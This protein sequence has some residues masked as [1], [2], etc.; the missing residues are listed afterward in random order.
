M[1]SYIYLTDALNNGL[2]VAKPIVS[3]ADILIQGTKFMVTAIGG[4]AI[5]LKN[6]TG[7]LSVKGTVIAASPTTALS[8][9]PEANMFDAIG[10]VYESG[11]ADGSDCWFVISGI[12]EVLW[13][14]STTATKG[15]V[16][17][18]DTTDGR[19]SNVEVPSS[20]PVVAEHFREIGH[21]LEDNAG[22]IN[23]LVKVILHF[24]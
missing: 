3:T 22:G 2:N 11:I 17:L 8:F 5:R 13:K 14:N 16:A 9:T 23:Q 6:K 1:S 10:V 21:V 12:A 20:N 7:G 18:S 15:Y 19:A 4:I 24:N